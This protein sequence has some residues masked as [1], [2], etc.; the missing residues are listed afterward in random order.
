MNM[1]MRHVLTR[2][3]SVVLKDIQARGAET[4]D[5]CPTQQCSLRVNHRDDVE[6]QIRYRR[7]MHSRNDQQGA[8]F[9]LADIHKRQE[10][11]RA[12]HNCTR[13][14]PRNVIA[15][16]AGVTRS[17]HHRQKLISA[18]RTHWPTCAVQLRSRACRDFHIAAF[19]ACA[20]SKADRSGP[21]FAVC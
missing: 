9:V 3:H 7:R 2:I 18:A 16:S 15:E 21:T 20:S 10:M 6:R 4:P 11:L 17:Y 14:R 1:E 12:P 13:P 19:G 5:Q 8:L